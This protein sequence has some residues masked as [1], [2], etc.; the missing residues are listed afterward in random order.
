MCALN[1]VVS[2]VVLFTLVEAQQRQEESSLPKDLHLSIILEG[3]VATIVQ[4]QLL[5]FKMTNKGEPSQ[6][7]VKTHGTVLDSKD[8]WV[9]LQA[10]VVN[11][12]EGKRA[13]LVT[14]TATLDRNRIEAPN[15]ADNA[16]PGGSTKPL[17]RIDQLSDVEIETWNRIESI[18]PQ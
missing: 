16:N 18:K 14:I 9:T 15:P 8:N 6:L 10:V 12:L 4:D 3:D 5:Q 13:R 17:A 11:G 7:R 2:S 1:L